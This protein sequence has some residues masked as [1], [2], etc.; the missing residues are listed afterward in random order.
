MR[1]EAAS[2]GLSGVPGRSEL[3]RGVPACCHIFGSYGG[4]CWSVEPVGRGP[5]SRVEGLKKGLQGASPPPA[6]QAAFVDDLT[7][8]S[9]RVGS[10]AFA[11]RSALRILSDLLAPVKVLARSLMVT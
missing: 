2:P 1:R 4:T 5:S 10:P 8:T 7:M 6:D 3:Q 11:E 9:L